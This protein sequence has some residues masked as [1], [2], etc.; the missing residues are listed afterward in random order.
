MA[1]DP[2]LYSYSE[3]ND[4]GNALHEIVDGY[5]SPTVRF[6]AIAAEVEAM[7][8]RYDAPGQCAD[9][10]RTAQ[11]LV[12][13]VVGA[14]LLAAFGGL[15]SVYLLETG[16]L[17]TGSFG[18]WVAASAA[19]AAGG[20]LWGRWR[21][22][23]ISAGLAHDANGLRGNLHTRLEAVFDAELAKAMAPLRRLLL[24]AKDEVRAQQLAILEHREHVDGIGAELDAFADDVSA[25]YAEAKRRERLHKH[26]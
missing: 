15:S 8:E 25:S 11:R 5:V 22:G 6:E 19:V 13:T 26:V 17:A 20:A 9:T 10:A 24:D 1:Q 21:W 7:E 23:R 16:Q 14:E 18:T 4:L 12:N 2:K 3:T